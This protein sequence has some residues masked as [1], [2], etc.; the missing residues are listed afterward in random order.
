MTA[1]DYY[2]ILNLPKDCTETEIKKSYRRLAMK[3]HPDKNGTDEAAKI[4]HDIAEAYLVLCDHKKRDIYDK[5]GYEGLKEKMDDDED[6]FKPNPQDTFESFF[7]SRNPF[8]AFEFGNA[9]GNAQLPKKDGPMKGLDI[10]YKLECTLMELLS[11]C[12][13]SFEFVKKMQQVK[14]GPISE[15]TKTLTIHIKAGWKKGTK[16]VFANEGDHLFGQ[17]PSD[18]IFFLE[19]KSHSFFER[20]GNNLVYTHKISLLDSLLGGSISIKTLDNR[21]IS[22]A[23]P[24]IV[25]PTYQKI[26]PGL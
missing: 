20:D 23:C 24:E 2:E 15:E 25:H 21:D 11:G 8:A 5:I 6:V 4:F 18:V 17:L 10:V 19:Q 9:Q 12:I 16:I 26:I 13:K 7:G 3:Y 14:D 22:I 1:K